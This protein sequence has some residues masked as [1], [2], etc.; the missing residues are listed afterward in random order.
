M[1]APHQQRVIDERDDLA[2]KI[3]RLSSFMEIDAYR[4]LPSEERWALGSQLRYMR[5]Y[6]EALDARIAL[7]KAVA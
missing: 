7:W 4:A 5:G 6:L 2:G 1:N 3:D